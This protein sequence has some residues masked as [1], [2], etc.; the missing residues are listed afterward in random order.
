MT[1]PTTKTTPANATGKATG[2]RRPAKTGDPQADRA[3]NA[4]AQA[5][6]TANGHGPK[7]ARRPR[8]TQRS[9]KPG[10]TKTQ[11]APKPAPAPAPAPKDKTAAAFV[12][13]LDLALIAAAGELFERADIP[14][15]MR[16]D[17]AQSFANQL[18]HLSRPALGWPADGKLPRPVRSDWA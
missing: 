18:H 9:P 3:A 17:V 15:K 5:K 8:A 6:A 12:R 11:P 10:V 1:A 7:P 2:S 16:R 14:A 4:D 13:E